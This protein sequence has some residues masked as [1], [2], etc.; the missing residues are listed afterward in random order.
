MSGFV[1]ALVN[2][3]LSVMSIRFV[4]SAALAVW[5]IPIG[6]AKAELFGPHYRSWGWDEYGPFRPHHYRSWGWGDYEPFRQKRQ[7][8]N[9]S[10]ELEQ[11]PKSQEVVR[12]P[13]QIIISIADQRI[14]VYDDGTLIARSSV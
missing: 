3:R 5:L 1:S 7:R 14:S 8:A 10:Y 2:N 6:A 4:L 11:K 9:K 12:G 13:L